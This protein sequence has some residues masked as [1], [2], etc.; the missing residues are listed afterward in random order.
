MSKFRCFDNSPNGVEI[1]TF[2]VTTLPTKTSYDVGDTLDT[3]GIVVT[4]TAD[5]MTGN[6][7]SY[8]TFSPTTLS[9]IG[10]TAITVEYYDKT[11]TFNVTVDEPIGTL[12]NT[13]WARIQ[14]VGAAGT[15]SQYWAV[16]D[17]KS[18][19]VAG[20]VGN[21]TVASQT[22]KV[23]VLGFNHNSVNG[24]YF[25]CFMKTNNGS[26]RKVVLYPP[27]RTGT[28]KTDGSKIFNMNHWGNNTYGGWAGCDMRYDILGSTDTPPSGYGSAAV[29]GRVG[30]DASST[31]A[32]SPVPNTV[33]SI[34]PS[35]LRAVMAPW[36]IYT[37]NVGTNGSAEHVTASVDYLPLLSEYETYQSTGWA[38]TTEAT[39]QKQFDF[40]KN[41]GTK[42]VYAHDNLGNN[43]QQR[44]RSYDRYSSSQK[45][46]VASSDGGRDSFYADM[47]T[48][49]CSIFRVA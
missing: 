38:N 7:A 1:D 18:I 20:T 34:L 28:R 33:M 43:T 11:T 27:G 32:T 24:I 13:S 45:F 17:T 10:T 48:P 30:Y 21:L 12:E 36:T 47:T 4:A 23:F 22:M 35:D 46:V 5:G 3:T 31:T 9:D 42:M 2:A 15:G 8:C 37:D 26:N 16:G 14:Q 19:T 44:F 6:V 29:S 40:Y 39:Y 41:G 49:I 25:Q